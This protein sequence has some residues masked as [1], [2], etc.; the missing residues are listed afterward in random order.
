MSAIVMIWMIEWA[1]RKDTLKPTEWRQ[2]M[3]IVK[4]ILGQRLE[5]QRFE[6][7]KITSNSGPALYQL[8]DLGTNQ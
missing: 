7:T 4:V 5:G 3:F 6:V 2:K 8:W 1:R